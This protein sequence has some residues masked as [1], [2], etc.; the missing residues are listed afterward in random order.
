MILQ[1]LHSTDFCLLGVEIMIQF[2]QKQSGEC[3]VVDLRTIFMPFIFRFS[4]IQLSGNLANVVGVAA[5]SGDMI[6]SVIQMINVDRIFDG[7]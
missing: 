1:L 2:N 4:C 7:R 5:A 6:N 3:L